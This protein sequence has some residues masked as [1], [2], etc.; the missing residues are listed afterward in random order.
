[1]KWRQ[2]RQEILQFYEILT[3]YG[4]QASGQK[5]NPKPKPFLSVV[6]EVFPQNF[7][8]FN[9]LYLFQVLITR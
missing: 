5:K 7:A 6:K 1:M 3:I 9:S 2:C 4:I 8:D